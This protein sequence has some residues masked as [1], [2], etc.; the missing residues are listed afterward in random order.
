MKALRA[1]TINFASLADGIHTYDYQIDNKFLENFKESFVSTANVKVELTMNKM[2]HCLELSFE[3]TG[4][5]NTVCDICAED[6]D[7]Q[8][9]GSEFIIVKIVV[10]PPSE[11]DELNVVYIKDSEHA[12]NVAQ[13]I[14]EMLL[15]SMPMRKVHPSLDD[16]KP[17]CNPEVLKYLSSEEDDNADE[18]DNN[19]Q[20]SNPI[21]DELKKLKK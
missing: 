6:F 12:I 1:Y 20:S 15:L 16:E 3:L 10:E 21:W 19:E 13:M 9:S 4:S 7:L 14:Y 2:A 8:L 17:G 18:A 5:V 11:T